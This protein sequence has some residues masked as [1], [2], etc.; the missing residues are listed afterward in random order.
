MEI[1]LFLVL[2]RVTLLK[3][4][5]TVPCGHTNAG[6]AL[7]SRR[8]CFIQCEQM[9]WDARRASARFP[10]AVLALSTFKRIFFSLNSFSFVQV[11]HCRTCKTLLIRF[12][13]IARES[14]EFCACHAR[15]VCSQSVY[16]NV[17]NPFRRGS[18]RSTI[19]VIIACKC[20]R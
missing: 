10:I 14:N 18:N 9:F 4:L 7:A 2:L 6:M 20:S 17:P 16:S 8:G 15:I 1:V 19:R 12:G 13:R 11:R 3:W 5:K